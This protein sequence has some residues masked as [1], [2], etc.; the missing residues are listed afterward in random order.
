MRSGMNSEWNPMTRPR[1]LSERYARVIHWLLQN[2]HPARGLQGQ[3]RPRP[4]RDERES[5]WM[6]SGVRLFDGT[7]KLAPPPNPSKRARLEAPVETLSKTAA[8][9]PYSILHTTSIA[10]ADALTPWNS[11]VAPMIGDRTLRRAP[12]TLGAV[13]MCVV[14]AA[15]SFSC[16]RLSRITYRV[17]PDPAD[18]SAVRVSLEL[19]PLPRDSLVLG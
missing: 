4:R 16:Q 1:H 13:A 3:Q 12:R 18:T 5:S 8:R 15:N 17:G 14:V 10:E 2:L 6:P 7:S 19:N 11:D 9:R